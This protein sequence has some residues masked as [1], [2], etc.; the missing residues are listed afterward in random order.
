MSARLRVDLQQMQ[1]DV[2]LGLILF[3]ASLLSFE[4]SKGGCAELDTN[5]Q[6][7]ALSLPVLNLPLA[8]NRQH[9]P[10]NVFSLVDPDGCFGFLGKRAAQT[11]Y[12]RVKT[13]LHIFF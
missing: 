5:H 8:T 13:Y 3:F 1:H 11:G 2:C 10:F 6:F 7:V 4:V 9:T 12:N